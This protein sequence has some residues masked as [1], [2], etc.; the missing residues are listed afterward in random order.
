[1]MRVAVTGGI[2]SGKSY[3]CQRLKA[4]G[5]DVYDCD[6][7][8]KRLMR[9]SSELK[10]QLQKLIGSNAYADGKLNKPV[11]TQYLL[12]SEENARAVD[13]I[14]HPAVAADFLH[15]GYAWM[16]TAILF[17]SGFNRYV[18]KIV[19]VTAPTETRIRRVMQRDGITRSQVLEWM[20]R[21]LPQEE[22][23]NRSDYIIVNDGNCNIDR[24][25]TNIINE[26]NK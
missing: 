12:A 25:I 3:V 16:E 4:H 14:V 17:E 19:C 9:S 26:I 18:D 24:Q 20:Q 11:L 22:V 13:N 8:A 7:A 5:I 21:Q 1:M 23:A 6:A 10:Q 15:S 2:G